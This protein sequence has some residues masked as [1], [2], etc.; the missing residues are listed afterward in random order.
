MRTQR[1]LFRTA[2]FVA[3][4]AAAL[5]SA[6]SSPAGADVLSAEYDATKCLGDSR[7]LNTTDPI[8][9]AAIFTRSSGTIRNVASDG[10]KNIHCPIV[11][12]TSA[13]GV[14]NDAFRYIDIPIETASGATVS[15]WVNVWST[16]VTGPGSTNN[17]QTVFMGSR[18]TTGTLRINGL[19][20]P[21]GYWPA[22]GASTPAKWKYLDLGCTLPTSSKVGRYRVSE[23]GSD[24]PGYR[25]YGATNC[26]PDA[27]NTI[28]WRNIPTT[29]DAHGGYIMGQ[30][31]GG[32]SKWAM[33]CPVPN[34]SLVTVSVGRAGSNPMGCNFNSTDF[35]DFT[36]NASQHWQG[37]SW[38][39]EVLRRDVQMAVSVPLT[40]TFNL[41][42]GQNQA[43][44]DGKLLSYRVR[45]QRPRPWSVSASRGL[46]PGN[47]FDNSA[48]TR[49]TT[50]G[51][52][53]AGD[54]IRIDLGSSKWFDQV[55]QDS[56]TSSND[57]ARGLVVEASSN[58][59]GPWTSLWSGTGT[60]R[61]VNAWF[62]QHYARYI[63][64]RLT[65]GFSSWWSI[66][67]LQVH[68]INDLP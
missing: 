16:E 7:D 42:C 28:L 2:L 33:R 26:Q 4:S 29:L 17:R 61:V 40:Q 48:S 47:V 20:T 57:Y 8:T 25:I 38:P 56:G 39:S 51:N 36:W 31:S 41:L 45:P 55:I 5:V 35:S 12:T 59:S 30:A 64:V 49:F 63:R 24:Q 58:A 54:W 22:D 34:F 6:A 10:P 13:P 37:A 62:P 68:G 52:A 14:V 46:S 50:N 11:K 67:D 9:G 23:G 44:G 1:S 53:Q 15:C 32:A 19:S 66:H 3:A 43:N 18:S 65:S 60:S 21:T 27:T